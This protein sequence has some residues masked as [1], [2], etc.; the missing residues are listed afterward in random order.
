MEPLKAGSPDPIL[1]VF[2]EALVEMQPPSMMSGSW[3]VTV[4]VGSVA[5]PQP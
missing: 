1:R 3:G 4:T 2:A 5:D